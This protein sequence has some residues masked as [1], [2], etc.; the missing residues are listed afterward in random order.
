MDAAIDWAQHVD[1]DLAADISGGEQVNV[2][3]LCPDGTEKRYVVFGELVPHYG[4]EE[5]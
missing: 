5:L 3:V 4:A 2:R 1:N